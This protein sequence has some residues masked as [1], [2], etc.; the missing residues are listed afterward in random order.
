MQVGDT[1]AQTRL[2]VLSMAQVRTAPTIAFS[3]VGDVLSAATPVCIGVEITSSCFNSSTL[4]LFAHD[5]RVCCS[6]E[7]GHSART[8]YLFCQSK[9]PP[10]QSTMQI[11][12]RYGLIEGGRTA[13]ITSIQNLSGHGLPRKSTVVYHPRS[14]KFIYIKLDLRQ[15]QPPRPL[16][17]S[18]SGRSGLLRNFPN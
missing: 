6:Q 12:W 7:G 17:K 16:D 4:K 11:Q 2:S 18:L 9:I 13:L 3:A 15:Q 5:A 8:T 10:N 1:H 14:F